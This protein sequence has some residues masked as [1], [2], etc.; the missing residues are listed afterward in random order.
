M[1]NASTFKY[2]L[3]RGLH[4]LN[5]FGRYCRFK[6]LRCTDHKTREIFSLV[7]LVLLLLTL[8]DSPVPATTAY[9]YDTMA[10]TRRAI[11]PSIQQVMERYFGLDMRIHNQPPNFMAQHLPIPV[12]VLQN[13]EVGVLIQAVIAVEP[14][15]MELDVMIAGNQGEEDEGEHHHETDHPMTPPLDPIVGDEVPSVSAFDLTRVGDRAGRGMVLKKW[16]QPFVQFVKGVLRRVNMLIKRRRNTA[17]RK[18]QNAKETGL[19]DLQACFVVKE[20]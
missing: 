4:K 20:E 14:E 7:L 1:L 6:H 2:F 12:P 15:V 13:P 18:M 16:K 10:Y 3:L 17:N 11:Y 5:A 19:P 8:F 9:S